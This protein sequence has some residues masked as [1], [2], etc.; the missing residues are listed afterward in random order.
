MIV[1]NNLTFS[2]LNYKLMYVCTVRKCNVFILLI[3]I[4]FIIV[5]SKLMYS[6]FNYKLMFAQL[7]FYL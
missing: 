7:L 2:N 1:A 5:D 3:I 6:N 4:C